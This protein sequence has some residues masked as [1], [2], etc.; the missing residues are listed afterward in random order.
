MMSSSA[1][2]DTATADSER[3]R[4]AEFAAFLR[5]RRERISP[6]EVG[7]RVTDRRRTPG[8][9]REE[10]AELAAVGLTWYTWLEQ[11]RPVRASAQVLQAIADALLLDPTE[12]SYLFTLA[13]VAR[14]PSEPEIA[15]IPPFLHSLIRQLDPFPAAVQNA[16]WEILAFNRGYD[17]LIEL[18]SVPDA[19]RNA[20]LLYFTD[21]ARR[22]QW[23]EW[24]ENAPNLVSQFRAA[25]ARHVTEPEWQQ[26]LGRLRRASPDFDRLW[27]E[28]H[29]GVY[30]STPKR[31]RHPVIGLLSLTRFQLWA[32][33]REDGLLAVGYTPADA[34]TAVKI[35][36]LPALSTLDL[37][38]RQ[39][40]AVTPGPSGWDVRTWPC[41]RAGPGGAG[42]RGRGRTRVTPASASS[43][44]GPDALGARRCRC[45]SAR[46]RRPHPRAGRR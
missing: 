14:P 27:R 1:G 45:S 44:P 38:G 17:G 15:D 24:E 7:I 33:P 4:R 12:R 26:L 11:G 41:G 32:E 16:R 25:M 21:P 30:T 9:R 42:R 35:R 40:G 29:V 37:A 18:N 31:F 39:A 2:A 3:A 36:R 28:H 34:A 6:H 20:L 5:S 43:R 46:V 22:R 8:L 10:V 13:G 19:D 23:L